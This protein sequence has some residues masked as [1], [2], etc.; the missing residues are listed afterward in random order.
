MLHNVLHILM[1]DTFLTCHS[2]PMMVHNV[3]GDRLRICGIERARP[4]YGIYS[5]ISSSS[6]LLRVAHILMPWNWQ[7]LNTKNLCGVPWG[8]YC[9]SRNHWLVAANHA[10]DEALISNLPLHF[11]TLG[12]S[13]ISM[14]NSWSKRIHRINLGFASFFVRSY[15]RAAWSVKLSPWAPTR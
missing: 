3:V 5:H 10:L 13:L 9:P 4:T 11:S 1:S 2:L 6:Y 12:L 15:L 7:C 14:S 8:A